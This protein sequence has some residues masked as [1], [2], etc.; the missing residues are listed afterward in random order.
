MKYQVYYMPSQELLDEIKAI[1]KEKNDKIRQEY[2]ED[3]IRETLKKMLNIHR[4]IAIEDLV[5]ILMD[6]F[7]IHKK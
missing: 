3:E 4:R 2:E 1:E 6:H 7:D 5:N